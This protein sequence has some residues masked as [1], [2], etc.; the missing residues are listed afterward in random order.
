MMSGFSPA[1][2]NIFCEQG[3]TALQACTPWSMLEE[4]LENERYTTMGE[5]L[6]QEIV[7]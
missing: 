3:I 2:L 6:G 1:L 7:L 4:T 5:R